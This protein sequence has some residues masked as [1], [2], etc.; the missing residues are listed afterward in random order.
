MLEFL[1]GH[2][3]VGVNPCGSCVVV[4]PLPQIA[5]LPETSQNN[6]FKIFELI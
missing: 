3:L 5:M 1:V 4:A 2:V 6:G